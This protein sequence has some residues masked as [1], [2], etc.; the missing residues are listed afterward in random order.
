MF[1]GGGAPRGALGIAAAPGGPRNLQN[2]PDW[3]AQAGRPGIAP[4]A[5]R[6][7]AGPGGM[8]IPVGAGG[9][10]LAPGAG[11]PP[12]APVAAP[13]AAPHTLAPVPG[14]VMGGGY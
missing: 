10:G 13:A 1:G 14:G 11:A 12:P 6:P 2:Y 5:P 8:A 7:A 3:G 9:F 4:P